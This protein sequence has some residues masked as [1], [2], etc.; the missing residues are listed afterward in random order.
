MEDSPVN[1]RRKRSTGKST[2]P[3]VCRAGINQL[4][5][6]ILLTG[7]GNV[8]PALARQMKKCITETHNIKDVV[9]HYAVS[10]TEEI[11]L[12]LRDTGLHGIVLCANASMS[13][14]TSSIQETLK[15]L[16]FDLISTS[17]HILNLVQPSR[18]V[19]SSVA[20]AIEKLS[21][22]YNTPIINI[23]L[24]HERSVNFGLDRVC[25]AA[26]RGA[27]FI[28]GYEHANLNAADFLHLFEGSD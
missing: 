9:V 26:L 3:L 12:K 6:R 18:S 24:E 27:R 17:L 11:A 5:F 22:A 7:P 13:T 16:D 19:F 4:T 8:I 23:V 15:Y 2:L 21:I 14:T 10:L 20:D 28:Y 25:T 1:R